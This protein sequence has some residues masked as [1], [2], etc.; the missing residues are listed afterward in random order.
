M[1]T[2]KEA[3]KNPQAAAPK[4]GPQAPSAAPG[5]KEPKAKKEKKAKRVDYPGLKDAEG[6]PVSFET[7]PTDFDSKI[8]RPLPRRAF[9]NE[10]TFWELKVTAAEKHLAKV[11]Q[12]AEDAKKT[13]GLADKGK[14]KKL[15][16]MLA[17]AKE[18]EAEL[19]GELGADELA[20]LLAAVPEAKPKAAA[21]AAD[22]PKA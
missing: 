22:A 2:H 21:P 9:K 10:A 1:A 11:K 20:K 15:L 13:G 16:N 18:L 6:K 7:I 3:P 12:M 8:H 19:A 4:A 17:R 5:A 14:A